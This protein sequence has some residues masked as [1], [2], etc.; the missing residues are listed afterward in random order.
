MNDLEK[1]NLENAKLLFEIS[2]FEYESELARSTRLDDKVNKILTFESVIIVAFTA[3]VTNSN[4]IEFLNTKLFINLLLSYSLTFIF[5]TV[6]A[7][8]LY[9]LIDCLALKNMEKLHVS[10]QM[11][12]RIGRLNN[13]AAHIEVVANYSRITEKNK[14]SNDLK[15]EKLFKNHNLLFLALFV[16]CLYVASL[17][18]AFLTPSKIKNNELELNTPIFLSTNLYLTK[19]MEEKMGESSSSKDNSSSSSDNQ[20]NTQDSLFS[21][22]NKEQ[23]TTNIALE[24]F[25]GLL[26]NNIL[27]EDKN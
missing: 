1:Q 25:S 22:D 11:S 19:L 12:K 6:I 2:K 15:A 26:G 24:D 16:I 18:I 17:L 10:E 4:I 5:F 3:L 9:I 14:S 21:F 13:T 23:H 7:I 20:N 8:S 27:L